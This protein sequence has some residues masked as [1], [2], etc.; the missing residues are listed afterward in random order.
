MTSPP[1]AAGAAAQR[2]L[3]TTRACDFFSP[4]SKI[5]GRRKARREMAVFIS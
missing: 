3:A 4:K 2:G 5:E 1:K